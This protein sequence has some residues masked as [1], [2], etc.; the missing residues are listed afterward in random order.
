MRSQRSDNQ[1]ARVKWLAGIGG[2]LLRALACTWRIRETNAAP[3]RELRARGRP[4]IFALWHGRL[5]PLLWH[6]RAEGI[7]VLI[8][9]HADGEL[10][11]RVAHSLGFRTVRGS[12]S[13][14]GDRALLRMIRVVEQGGD[15]AF[16]PDGPRGP[17]ETVTPG[18][19]VT[20]QRTGAP[21]IPIAAG[22]RRAWRLQSWD[23]FMIPKPFAQVTIAYG[24]PVYVT[25]STARQ[26]ATDAPVLQSVMREVAAAADA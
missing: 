17:A 2:L 19:L 21:I 15:A 6:H 24:Q 18:A 23:R 25:A 10:V 7:A 26:A 11:A 20:A 12:T 5:L 4:V 1:P 3:L 16:T 22:S 14:G 9:E 8:S 13:R